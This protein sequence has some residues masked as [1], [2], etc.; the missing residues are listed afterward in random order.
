MTVSREELFGGGR[1]IRTPGR[2][3]TTFALQANALGHY[4]TPPKLATSD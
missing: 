2:P 4:A 3:T 1:E